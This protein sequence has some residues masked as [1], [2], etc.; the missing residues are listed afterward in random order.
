[1]HLSLIAVRNLARSHSV[2]G[3]GA[4][5]A[6]HAASP[7][8]ESD[9][10]RPDQALQPIPDR[11]AAAEEGRGGQEVEGGAEGGARGVA[12]RKSSSYIT[13]IREKLPLDHKVVTNFLTVRR[14]ICIPFS[15]GN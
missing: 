10:V 9:A 4:S 14:G 1:M 5:D 2:R 8:E 11:S 15:K 7:V 13:P 12:E 3:Q 6:S